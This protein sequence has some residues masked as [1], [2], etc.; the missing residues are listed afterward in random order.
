MP[1]VETLNR[2]D[3]YLQ[4]ISKTYGD[5]FPFILSF[6]L[7]ISI[8]IIS[9]LVIIFMSFNVI[10]YRNLEADLDYITK[11]QNYTFKPLEM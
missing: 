6:I 1:F 5:K 4:Y 11:Y 8:I 9:T 10:S 7:V 2:D 3:L